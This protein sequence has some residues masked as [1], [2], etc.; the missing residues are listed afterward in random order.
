MKISIEA[1]AENSF[2][3]VQM[4]VHKTHAWCNDTLSDLIEHDGDEPSLAKGN[5]SSAALV[6]HIYALI[7]VH[8]LKADTACQTAHRNPSCLTLRFVAVLGDIIFL[9]SASK[10]FK[11]SCTA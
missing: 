9:K 1:R 7:C 2:K 6:Q 4:A 10:A 3:V 5:N 8:V 11:I